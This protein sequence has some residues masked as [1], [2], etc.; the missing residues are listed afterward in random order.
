MRLR[1]VIK[2][3]NTKSNEIIFKREGPCLVITNI[4]A[5]AYDFAVYAAL[6]QI[7]DSYYINVTQPY[8]LLHS[9]DK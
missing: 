7:L 5:T 6:P 2:T 9:K 4:S 8:E 1:L 3:I